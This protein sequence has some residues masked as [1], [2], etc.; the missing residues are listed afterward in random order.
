MWL[1]T[2]VLLSVVSL[3][4]LFWSWTNHKYSYFRRSNIPFRKPSFPLGNIS[5]IGSQGNVNQ[6]AK[7]L[8]FN[9]RN[10]PIGG[11]I[12]I[13]FEPVLVVTDLNLIQ[14]ILVTHFS[15]FTDHGFFMNER[16]DP[17]SAMLFM[18]GGERWRNMRTKMSPTFSN[19]N[20]R[21]MFE[22]VHVIGWDMLQHLEQTSVQTQTPFNPKSLAMRFICDSIGSCGFGLD[23]GAFRQADPYLLK[24]AENMFP[25]PRHLMAYW[26]LS[27]VYDNLA[28]FLRLRVM[29]KAVT[30]YFSEIITETVK[31]REANQIVRKDF[32]NLL[33]Q[34]KNKGC[35]TEDESGEM[36][37][38][39]SYD[40]LQAQAF[41]IF[42]AGFHTSRV[43]LTF[44][45]FE[46]AGNN[47][48]QERLREEIL[49]HLNEDGQL[50]YDALE[51]MTYLQQVVDGGEG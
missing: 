41:V 49:S 28:R 42:F 47:C 16:D 40:E 7:N 5:S 4:L 35:L 8:Y 6:W 17:L 38:S 18:L 15:S 20:T 29:P 46:L 45:L 21:N 13:G 33:I 19:F 51:R 22:T 24:I 39:I 23:C 50:T 10:Q 37:G 44:A 14:S 27:G 12:F 2:I 11:G 30:K 25:Y 9:Y 26:L 31:Y 48:V 1:L 3:V 36:L 32:M 43:T 34:I